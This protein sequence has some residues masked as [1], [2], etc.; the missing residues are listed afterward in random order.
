MGN[1]KTNQQEFEQ[2]VGEC[3]EDNVQQRGKWYR[4]KQKEYGFNYAFP[5]QKSG[6]HTSF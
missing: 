5:E 2:N 3:D 1:D 4:E 6:R